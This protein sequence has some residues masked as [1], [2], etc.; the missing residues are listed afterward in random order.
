MKNNIW[1]NRVFFAF[2]SILTANFVKS[3]RRKQ[4]QIP[5]W[6]VER[7]QN[8]Y[9]LLNHW[10]ELKNEGKSVA[11]YFEDMGYSHIA[12][13]GMAELGNRL[14]EE[15]ESSTVQVDY[16]IDREIACSIARID[17]VYY[18]EDVLPETDV[19]VVTPYSVFEEIKTLLEKRV[20]CPVISLEDVVWSV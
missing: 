5:Q 9:W 10:L 18:P 8:H 6:N 17:E 14:M 13:Y 20:K 7:F 3:Y 4:L 2:C 19:I 15:L 12:I 1:L 16:G 11:S